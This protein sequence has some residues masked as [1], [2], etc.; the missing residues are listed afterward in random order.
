MDKRD[1]QKMGIYFLEDNYPN[2]LYFYELIVFTGNRSESETNSKVN[3]EFIFNSNLQRRPLDCKY[4]AICR[5]KASCS[6]T[7]R[8]M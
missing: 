5:R 7:W 2:E 1:E 4:G 8:H 3:F 6:T